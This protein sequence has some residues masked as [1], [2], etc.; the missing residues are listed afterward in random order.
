[1]LAGM[2]PEATILSFD[3]MPQAYVANQYLKTAMPDRV[4]PIEKSIEL[5][6]T[7]G[8][9]SGVTGKIVIMPAWKM[10]ECRKVRADLFWNSA[11]FQEM[12]PAVACNYLSLV[13]EMRPRWVSIDALPGGNYL[14]EWAPGK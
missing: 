14:G 12:E 5:D 13:K 9:I 8:D 7:D 2:R 1:M 11:S 3:V 10:S 4:V 6:L